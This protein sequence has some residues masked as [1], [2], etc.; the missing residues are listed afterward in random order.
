MAGIIPSIRR[1]CRGGLTNKGRPLFFYIAPDVREPRP[2]ARLGGVSWGETH[3]SSPLCSS[4]SVD[5]KGGIR[6]RANIPHAPFHPRDTR[7]RL[8]RILPDSVCAGAC[9]RRLGADS[10]VSE[11]AQESA[12]DR[13]LPQLGDH[14]SRRIG[15]S[16]LFVW[17]HF[18]ARQ[19]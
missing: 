7:G 8:R 6:V 9:R 15:E 4:I 17:P 19:H 18:H 12:P 14:L 11:H 16:V 10:I 2:R 1:I 5:L 13:P 3:E